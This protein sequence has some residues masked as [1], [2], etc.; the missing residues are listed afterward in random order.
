M[1]N[2]PE[3]SMGYSSLWPESLPETEANLFDLVLRELVLARKIVF[4]RRRNAGAVR[5]GLDGDLGWRVLC[6]HVC[7]LGKFLL[8]LR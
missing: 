7:Q 1:G 3:T 8:A 5:V 4:V 2:S 6:E